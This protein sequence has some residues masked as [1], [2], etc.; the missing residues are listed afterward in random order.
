[1]MPDSF[2]PAHDPIALALAEDIGPGDLTSRYFIAP[3]RIGAARIFMKQPGG[4]AGV[5]TAAEVFR[6]VDPVLQVEIVRPEGTA[7]ESG[8]EILHLSGRVASLL[9][10]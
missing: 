1:M 3:E 10:A 2:S 5:E 6:R 9:T 7:A 8:D 4:V